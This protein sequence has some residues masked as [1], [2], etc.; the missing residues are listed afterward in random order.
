MKITIDEWTLSC[1]LKFFEEGHNWWM[2][3]YK[4]LF[5]DVQRCKMQKWWMKLSL[6]L[7]NLKNV[8]RCKS[9][10][11]MN[12][13]ASP[14]LFKQTWQE[15]SPTDDLKKKTPMYR[16]IRS[17]STLTN[18]IIIFQKNKNKNLN[19]FIFHDLLQYFHMS[20]QII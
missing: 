16:S 20:N 3:G 2:K 13:C 14:G 8:K 10:A 6:R 9:D 4:G 1:I 5:T 18:W 17:I 7:F 15:K 19:H 12:E 11:G